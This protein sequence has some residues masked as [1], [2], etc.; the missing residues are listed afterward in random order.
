M[1]DVPTLIYDRKIA[2][3]IFYTIHDIQR[4]LSLAK[5]L[6]KGRNAPI[7][8]NWETTHMTLSGNDELHV[9]FEILMPEFQAY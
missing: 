3:W 5:T 9:V 7:W 4:S 2:A 6:I 8:R 1:T